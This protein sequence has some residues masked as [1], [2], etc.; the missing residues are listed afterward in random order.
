MKTVLKYYGPAILWA[1]FIFIMCI[2]DL[3]DISQASIFFPGFDKLAHC[4]FF[5]VLVV[6]YCSGLIKQQSVGAISYKSI[7]I[8]ILIAVLYGGIIQLFQSR[9]FIWR[10]G[11]WDDLF[12]DTVGAVMGG[13]SIMTTVKAINFGRK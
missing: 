9:V 12:A 2:I 8:I 1:L 11:D 3:G 5:F 4:G 10:T 7:T 6:F 13:F